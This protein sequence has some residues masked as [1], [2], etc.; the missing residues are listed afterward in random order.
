MEK[1][2]ARNQEH[3]A[4]EIA[5]HCKSSVV[6]KIFLKKPGTNYTFLHR[7]VLKYVVGRKE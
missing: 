6:K 1:G 2:V 3:Y 4:E 7:N 5:Q